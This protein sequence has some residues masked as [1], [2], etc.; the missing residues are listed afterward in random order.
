MNSSIRQTMK[1]K[2][3]ECDMTQYRL[4]KEINV[5]QSN[6][7]KMLNGKSGTVPK[8]WQEAFDYF[9]LELVVRE[10]PEPPSSEAKPSQNFGQVPQEEEE[11]LLSQSE[12]AKLVGVTA[13]AINKAVLR[14]E[15]KTEKAMYNGREVNRIP[16]SEVKKWKR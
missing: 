15:I 5:T 16:R 3:V 8:K 13:N 10:K 14:G 2:L 12:F 1:D 9:N 7:I 6:M 11:E 4:A